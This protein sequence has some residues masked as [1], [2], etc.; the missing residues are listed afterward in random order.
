MSDL[1][2]RSRQRGKRVTIRVNGTPVAAYS[3]FGGPGDNQYNTA[4]YLL[5]LLAKK[6]FYANLYYSQFENSSDS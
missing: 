2:I 6:G 1:R 5:E 3:T 4:W